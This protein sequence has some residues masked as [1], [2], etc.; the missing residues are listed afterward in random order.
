MIRDTKVWKWP[1]PMAGSLKGTS[2]CENSHTACEFTHHGV[3]LNGSVSMLQLRTMC[4]LTSVS[5]YTSSGCFARA[6]FRL[7]SAG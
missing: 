6:F 1:V 7:R 4:L 3:G 2:T 5:W